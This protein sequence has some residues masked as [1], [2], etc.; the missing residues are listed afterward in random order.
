M[1][2]DLRVFATTRRSAMVNLRHRAEW[3]SRWRGPI[4][5]ETHE[6]NVIAD[7]RVASA[8]MLIRAHGTLL[9]GRDVDYFVRVGNA[10]THSAGRWL[11]THEHM[12]LP[13]DLASR[14]A[15]MNLA[16]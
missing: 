12:S 15:V 7:E 11:I 6:I 9:D 13:V 1:E 3:F 16:P 8:H 10:C 14:R 2:A 5:H 4:G